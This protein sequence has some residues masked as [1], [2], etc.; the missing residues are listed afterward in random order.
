MKTYAPVPGDA[1]ARIFAATGAILCV[2]DPDHRILQLNPSAA[3][4][5][6]Y[7]AQSAVGLDFVQTCLPPSERARVA[8]LLD[9]T[10]A[11][12]GRREAAFAALGADGRT[13]TVATDF[14][15]LRGADGLFAEVIISPQDLTDHTLAPTPAK[16]APRDDALLQPELLD[17][18]D[19]GVV[20]VEPRTHIIERI[21]ATASR[22]I[23]LPAD[24]IVGRR[25]HC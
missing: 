2:L 9:R 11:D 25:C 13:R 24:Q 7:D 18:I 6:G 8:D 10:A 4:V 15:P 22:L 1:F 3:A 14:T 23:G 19:V 16:P 5:L 20:I 21:N 17:S 12:P